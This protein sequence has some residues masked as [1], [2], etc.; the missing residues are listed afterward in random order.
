M[1]NGVRGWLAQL[2]AF[3]TFASSLGGF[4]DGTGLAQNAQKARGLSVGSSVYGD[5][6]MVTGAVYGTGGKLTREMERDPNVVGEALEKR[7]PTGKHY[8]LKDGSYKAVFTMH[9]QHYEAEDGKLYD[10][11]TTLYEESELDTVQVPLSKA[12]AA[13]IRGMAARNKEKRLAGKAAE[14]GS[15][16]ALQ[17]PFDATLPKSF[18]KGYSVAKNG[19]T[20]TFIP[21]GS[22]S[23]TGA[24]YGRSGLIY[25]NAWTSTDVILQIIENGVKETIVLNSPD[26]P[27]SFRYEVVGPLADSLRSGEFRLQ[28]AWLIDANGQYRDVGQTLRVEG[29]KAYLD[30][31]AQLNGLTY[32]VAIDP[33]IVLSPAVKDACI[34]RPGGLNRYIYNDS[35]R[36]YKCGIMPNSFYALF[37]FDLSSIPM[38]YIFFQATLKTSLEMGEEALPSYSAEFQVGRIMQ[39]WSEP[40]TTYYLD[41]PE[42]SVQWYSRAENPFVMATAGQYWRLTPI[43]ID[44]TRAIKDIKAAGQDHGIAIAQNHNFGADAL[45]NE[46]TMGTG[47]RLEVVYTTKPTTPIVLSPNGGEVL[48]TVHTITWQPASDLDTPQW[49]LQYQIQISK[50]GGAWTDMVALTSPGATS[51]P[52]NFSGA[53]STSSNKIRIRAFDGAL[54]GEWD[55]SDGA[56]TVLANRAPNAPVNLSPGGATLNIPTRIAGTTPTVQWAFTDPDPGNVQSAFQVVV[57]NA[58]HLP[59]H[60]SGWRGTG[61]TSYAIPL[62]VLARGDVYYWRVKTRDNYGLESPFSEMRSIKPNVFPSLSISSYSDD[63]VLYHNVLTF[64]WAYSDPEGQAETAFQ[65]V[66][67]RDNWA[68]WAY[69]SGEIASNATSHTTAPLALGTWSFAIRVKD[70]MEWSDW[71]YRSNLSIPN[72]DSLPPTV[73]GNVSVTGKT[74]TTVTLGW[75]ASTDN[76][77]VAAYDIYNGTSPIGTS[78]TNSFTVTGLQPGTPYAFSVK[79][80]DDA[81]NTSAA[82]RTVRYITGA[83]E[84]RYDQAG[85]LDYIILPDGRTLDYQYDG[86]GNLIGTQ[87]Q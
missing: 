20:L 80:R 45:L 68:T 9:D 75:T 58:S 49:N 14:E 62:H 73:P 44:V 31:E 40:P 1:K 17:V 36:G 48:N 78:S 55:E 12:N 15:Y 56:F 42:P 81:G 65:V 66:G 22:T 5:S 16:K 19:E 32:P 4:A 79:A 8:L 52:Y 86:N 61:A 6:R 7:T 47:A 23:V 74:A 76:I 72:L 21:V 63:Q 30:I 10:I 83:L 51:Y 26:A 77:G 87:I 35:Y 37:K 64:T 3:L 11:D 50:D 41:S 57:Y 46:I 29:K 33:T 82:S 2:L 34:V 25:Q 71:S 24:V 43:D 27:S 39:D 69:N 85:R 18:R 54:Y 13:S 60:D 38:D 70:D 67:S 28:P 59:V 53:T 84:Y